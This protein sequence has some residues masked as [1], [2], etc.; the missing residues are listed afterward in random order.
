MHRLLVA[1]LSAFDA[2][3]AAA[4]GVAVVLAPLTVLW[5][6]GFGGTADWATLWPAGASVWQLGHLVPLFITL[7]GEYLAETGIDP[8]AASF[9]LSLAPLA[10][11]AFTAIFAARSGA[12][13]SR[14]DALGDRGRR[15]QR[16]VRGADD[17]D[18]D[19]RAQP[20]RRDPPVAGDRC[21]RRW[22]SRCPPSP[23]PS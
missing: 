13:A 6:V 5:V 20:D 11:A 1:L 10:L 3:I 18:R 12:R 19:H 21:S 22:C 8:D 2:A 7:P 16:R 9:V 17:A 23:E 15:R 14:A 4:V